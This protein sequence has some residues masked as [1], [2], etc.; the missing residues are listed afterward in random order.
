MQLSQVRR[1]L[2][3]LSTTELHARVG[4]VTV[5]PHALAAFRLAKL[6]IYNLTPRLDRDQRCQS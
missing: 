1:F 6:Q 2:I 5:P 4:L 3:F